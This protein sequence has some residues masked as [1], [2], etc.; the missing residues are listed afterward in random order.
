MKNNEIKYYAKGAVKVVNGVAYSRYGGK[1]VLDFY[2]D[3]SD[4]IKPENECDEKTALE[5]FVRIYG[6]SEGFN[7]NEK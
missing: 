6:T 1:Y 5:E 2:H 4:L 7:N 3:D